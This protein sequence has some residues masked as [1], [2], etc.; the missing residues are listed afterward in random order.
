MNCDLD[1][2]EGG[3]L[4]RSGGTQRELQLGCPYF[5]WDELAKVRTPGGRCVW[6]RW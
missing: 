3:A 2:K 6:S 4:G 1:Y 5:G